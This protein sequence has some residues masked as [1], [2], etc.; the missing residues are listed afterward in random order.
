MLIERDSTENEEK[1]RG[2]RW[3]EW[4]KDRVLFLVKAT[5]SENPRSKVA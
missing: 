3:G 4:G 2:E 1:G 5:G